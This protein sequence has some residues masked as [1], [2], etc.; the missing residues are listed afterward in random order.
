MP[1]STSL[2]SACSDLNLVDA[3]IGIN[4]H[5]L[6]KLGLERDYT[7]L[8]CSRKPFYQAPRQRIVAAIGGVSTNDVDCRALAFRD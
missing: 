2:I 7:I 4:A 1:L 6:S 3:A 5:K 8:I